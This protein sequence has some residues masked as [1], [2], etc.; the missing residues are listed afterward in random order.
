MVPLTKDFPVLGVFCHKVQHI[1]GLHDLRED[2][3]N[4]A[5]QVKSSVFNGVHR[6]KIHMNH[7][8][9]VKSGLSDKMTATFS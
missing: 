3:K 5:L 2:E 4:N 6:S 1:L 9:S 8:A 7:K